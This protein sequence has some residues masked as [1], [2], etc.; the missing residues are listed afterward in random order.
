MVYLIWDACR[1]PSAK[2]GSC[3]FT[4][5]ERWRR[6]QHVPPLLPGPATYY[7]RYTAP[8]F[9]PTTSDSSSRFRSRSRCICALRARGWERWC[10]RAAVLAVISAGASD[11]SRTALIT[12]SSPSI[13]ALDLAR[14]GPRQRI[15]SALLL[16]LLLLG[17]LQFAPA[18]REAAWP[19]FRTS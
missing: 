13:R 19:R 6:P 4:S 3:S 14:S 17:M 5:G 12:P 11:G 1:T 8:G 16:V 2:P 18:P 9:D 7:R 15:A 10:Y